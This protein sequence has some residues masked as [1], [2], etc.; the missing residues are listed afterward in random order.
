MGMV[1]ADSLQF[2]EVVKVCEE[3]RRW[4]F[5]V[6]AAP[7]RLPGGTGSLINPIAIF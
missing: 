2:E 6:V 5:L 7:L 1:C 4:E 3:E